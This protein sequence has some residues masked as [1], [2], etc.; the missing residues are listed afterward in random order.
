VKLLERQWATPVPQVKDLPELNAYLLQC[1]ERD[2]QRT[3]AGQS[4]TIG[5][6]FAFDYKGADSWAS[7]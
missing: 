4:E 1:C 2:A 6:R 3:I 5:A 7:D